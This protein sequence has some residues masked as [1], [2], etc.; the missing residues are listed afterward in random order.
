M[1][2][3]REAARRYLALARAVARARR[4]PW[5]P[6]KLTWILTEACSLRCA[7][8][9]LW[10]GEPAAGPTPEEVA[11]V[12]AAN[13]H[14]T[15]VNLSGGDFVERPDAPRLMA[16]IV[17]GLP[18]L[19]LLDFPTAGQDPAATLATL[20]P[21]LASDVPRIYVTVS[22]DGPDAVHDRVRGQPGAAAR[23]RE[24]LARLSALDRPGL[25]VVAG[26]T[27]SSRNLPAEPPA[28]PAALLPPGV[29]LADLHLN[30]AHH[31]DHY[32]RNTDAVAPPVDTALALVDHVL[33][34]RRLRSP[35]DLVERRYWSLARRFLTEGDVGGRCAAL[36]GSVYLAADM[37][38]YPCSIFDRPLG[39]LRDVD[40]SLRRL[41]EL[42]EG[43]GALAEVEARA[44]PGCWSPC[45]A[46]PT[47]LV[48]LGRPL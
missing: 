25:T 39:D 48:G 16:S 33:A 32:Y 13:P 38:V 47:L 29:D 5:D 46:F 23:A 45:E 3:R 9:H 7:T 15:W 4:G 18:D 34:R 27:L 40:W 19:A 31:S 11:A 42:A 12:V 6:F 24:T 1:P 43:P 36:R 8:C 37:R 20:E 22:L 21:A 41:A 35:L 10:I 26:Q 30:L 2:S 17:E 14:L 44:C 28:D